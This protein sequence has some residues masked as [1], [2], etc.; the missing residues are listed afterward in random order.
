ME[1][2]CR[3]TGSGKDTLVIVHGLYGSSD[4]WMSIAQKLGHKFRVILPDL[5]NH[6]QSPH[7]DRQDFEL[8]ADDL[9][10]TLIKRIDCKFILA[11]HSMGGKVAMRFA[12][13]H[14]ELLSKLVV[15]DIAPKSYIGKTGR[16]GEATD[17]PRIVDTLLNLHPERFDDRKDIDLELAHHFKSPSLRQFLLKNVKR[18]N[19]GKFYWQLNIEAIA[20]NFDEIMDGF[21]GIGPENAV[22]GLPTVFIIGGDSRY[23]EEGDS[24]IINRLFPGSQIVTIPGAGHWVHVDQPELFL[25]TLLYHID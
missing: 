18:N 22:K 13:K 7:S 2:F 25:S 19:S 23:V 10:E 20:R 1:L 4:N 24:L 12:M 3:E 21:S 11:G 16:G 6:G 5:R 17:H 14:P 9:Y 15:I 8:M